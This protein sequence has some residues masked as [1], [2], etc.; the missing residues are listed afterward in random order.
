MTT[1]IYP[2]SFD[3][4]TRGHYSVIEQACDVFD[5]VVIGVLNNDSK[6]HLLT[7][8]QRAQIASASLG[9]M[10][11]EPVIIWDGRLEGLIDYVREEFTDGDE[12]IHVVRGL[13]NTADFEYEQML[14]QYIYYARAS[15]A[16]FMPDP[17]NIVVSSTFVKELIKL[18]DN[19]ARDYMASREAYKKLL[20]FINE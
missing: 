17:E 11:E 1:A 18:D 7:G 4:M 20:D 5:K 13:R 2:G 9:P 8:D 3:P 10:S 15:T 6:N 16:Y 19:V 14:N 12:I